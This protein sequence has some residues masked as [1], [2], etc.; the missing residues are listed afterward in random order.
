MRKCANL[1]CFVQ[2][3]VQPIKTELGADT[4]T[5]RPD[6]E[7]IRIMIGKHAE[8]RVI[9]ACPN[10]DANI[11]GKKSPDEIHTILHVYAPS[12][13]ESYTNVFD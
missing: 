9:S 2:I 6:D 4:W 12:T 7:Y 5:P 3:E 10:N 11:E 13:W 1:F 8:L